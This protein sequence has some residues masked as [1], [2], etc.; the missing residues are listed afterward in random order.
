MT[1]DDDHV[2]NVRNVYLEKYTT[3]AYSISAHLSK[4]QLILMCFVLNLLVML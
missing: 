4:M 3:F 1:K 2:H